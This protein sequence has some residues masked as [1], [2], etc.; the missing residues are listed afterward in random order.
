MSFLFFSF[1]KLA[2]NKILNAYQSK[3]HLK[4][5]KDDPYQLEVIQLLQNLDDQLVNYT[6]TPKSSLMET[7][8]IFSKFNF[9]SSNDAQ[10]DSDLLDVKPTVRGLYLHGSVGCGKT[11]LMDLFCDNCCVDRRYKR[12]VHFHKFMLEFHYS[13]EQFYLCAS[14]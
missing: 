4:E 12:R 11:M 10:L 2:S 13:I 7:F 8:S 1:D 5:L 3:V 14:C 6:V 9:F